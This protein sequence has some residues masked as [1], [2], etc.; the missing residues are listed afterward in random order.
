MNF[1][2]TI[3][4]LIVVILGV[5]FVIRIKKL[6]G[7]LTKK[8]KKSLIIRLNIIMIL[9]ALT[10]VLFILSITVF[11]KTKYDYVKDDYIAVFHGGS[12]EMTYST[13]IYKID[14]GHANIGFEYI[15]TI[16]TTKSW[17]SSEWNIKVVESGEFTFTD[18]AF[19]ISRIHGAYDYVIDGYS[20]ERFT[21]EEYQNRFIMN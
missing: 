19:V 8:I 4:I 20:N 16:N 13:Y 2:L 15:N 14:N 6:E 10:L 21:I 7:N 11:K 5:E 12:G 1:I 3:I 18:E 17:G 9:I